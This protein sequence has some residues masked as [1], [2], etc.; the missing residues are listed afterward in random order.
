ME[1]ATTIRAWRWDQGEVGCFKDWSPTNG[2][3]VVRALEPVGHSPALS[4]GPQITHWPEAGGPWEKAMISLH[5]TL[6]QD[7][8]KAN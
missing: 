4:P 3:A 8:C 7:P 6:P 1:R 5:C 2:Q